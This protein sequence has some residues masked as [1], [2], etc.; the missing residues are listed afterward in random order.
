MGS[1]FMALSCSLRNVRGNFSEF[2]NYSLPEDWI[3]VSS[4]A[5]PGLA[6]EKRCLFDDEEKNLELLPNL[7]PVKIPQLSGNRITLWRRIS[8]R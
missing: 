8:Q 3:H 1:I 6:P 2:E 5:R 7:S 4:F